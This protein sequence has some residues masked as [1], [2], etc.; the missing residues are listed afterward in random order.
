[1]AVNSLFSRL[2]NFFSG[3]EEN[4]SALY[5]PQTETLRGWSW[6]CD[7]EAKLT[8]C[9][10]EVKNILNI[11]ETDFIGQT[12]F[13]F[14][15]HENSTGVF[16][17]A[18]FGDVFP[19]EIDVDY[20]LANEDTLPTRV[21]I[22][23][24]LLANG[25][26]IGWR[27][28]TQILSKDALPSIPARLE[29]PETNLQPFTSKPVV[30][31]ETSITPKSGKKKRTGFLSFPSKPASEPLWNETG[32]LILKSD[33]NV[34]FGGA[35]ISHPVTIGD[36][37]SGSLEI[38]DSN[39]NRK[40]SKEN[41]LL[42]QEVAAQ[43]SLALENA[44]LY[45]T[46]Q[47]ELGERVRAEK[48]TLKRN[49]DLAS[50]NQVGQQLNTLTNRKDIFSYLEN[51]IP[52]MIENP[53]L[54]IAIMSD[55][56]E[57][58]SFPVSIINSEKVY[59]QERLL[60]PGPINYVLEFRRPL[61]INSPSEY[62]QY[63]KENT[64]SAPPRSLLA[65]P[66]IVSEKNLGAILLE[67]FEKES[68][69]SDIDLEL[70]STI[71]TQAATSLENAYL[72]QEMSDALTTV[73]IRSRYQEFA[74]KGVAALTE[75]GTKALPDFLEMLGKA[76][77][78]SRVYFAEIQT[79]EAGQYWHANTCWQDGNILE[80]MPID[81]IIHMP[82]A[83][84]NRW[85]KDLV[86][87]GLST[88]TVATLP[89]SERILLEAQNIHSTLLLA[90]PGQSQTPSFLGFDQL[91]TLREWQ[92][93]E[94]YALQ[95]AANALSNTLAREDLL[96]QLQTSLDET[97][98][99][100][101]TSHRLALANDFQEM[102]AAL[103]QDIKNSNINR[104]AL[105][106][107]EYDEQEKP[108]TMAVTA[109]WY[110]GRGTPAP[111]IDTQ[112]DPET[113][114]RYFLTPAPNY[115]NDISSIYLDDKAKEFFNANNICSLAI[116][117]LWV[118]KKQI[119]TLLLASEE[120]HKF[121]PREKRTLP[122][123]VDQMAIAVENQHLFDQTEEA[124]EDTATLYMISN[125]IAQAS[126]L[127][128]HLTIIGENLLPLKADQA[129][130]VLVTERTE[131]RIEE[132]T[133]VGVYDK[134]TGYRKASFNI[135][136]VDFPIVSSI[137]AN[138]LT[139]PDVKNSSLDP[140]SKDTLLKSKLRSICWVPMK[141]AG[142]LLGFINVS[143]ERPVEFPEVDIRLLEA[144]GNGIAVALERQNFVVEAERR[145]LELKTAAELARDTTG[146]L[147]L[148]IL[149]PRFI[150]LLCERF[151]FH[152]ASIY[153]MDETSDFISIRESTS[154]ILKQ[155]TRLA[156]GSN[157]LVGQTSAQGQPLLSNNLLEGPYE[158]HKPILP[159]TR[160]EL[161][162][163]MKIGDRTIGVL[164]IQSTRFGAFADND[165]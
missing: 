92:Y 150:N 152:N 54:T 21:Q 9:S 159:E 121:S 13:S 66:M 30:I 48:E 7:R 90:V 3:F 81:K 16:E 72:F 122:P 45:S 117:P 35:S 69:F 141:S 39:P 103:T 136:S 162:T 106:T 41:Q 75:F 163:P 73:E 157:S 138:P 151:N 116:L 71:A 93:E 128:E 44:Q 1:M 78:A 23:S 43:L 40:W 156:V 148:D 158:L 6:E 98:Q 60:S 164:D 160:A 18:L 139:I 133:V 36:A 108:T 68:A 55:D 58:I 11:S 134:K 107:F 100:Y 59:Q 123:L 52:Q 149:L 17:S 91:E 51:I 95:V 2:D 135:K 125:K 126:L 120:M 22:F 127:S 76:S 38:L 113:F 31:Q 85:A 114:Q 130:I 20:I 109:T 83:L 49:Q 142:K 53:N 37:V 5:D 14:A 8:S 32:K 97:E 155:T 27:G 12:I 161:C 47:R 147:T 42:V 140:I 65:V 112:L 101:N 145:A 153:L 144:A 57:R 26:K 64:P 82:V 104:G 67:N 119:G 33:Q 137:E 56:G 15:L 79:D 132:L 96:D 115:Y 63:I 19:I 46:V 105:L 110:S 84:Y 34:V 129:S 77:N 25:K 143:A 88:G 62:H 70:L 29:T 146:E 28:F 124:L 131:G 80:Q 99:L 24:P 74:A 50:L 87:N 86:E 102:I 154:D 4:D 10:A 61:L 89:S 111:D 165:I 118:S 94:I